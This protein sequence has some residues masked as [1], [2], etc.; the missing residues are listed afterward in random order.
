MC[1][2]TNF[3]LFNFLMT[4]FLAFD[5]SSRF[6][7]LHLLLKSNK[8]TFSFIKIYFQSIR[9]FLK[10]FTARIQTCPPLGQTSVDYWIVR[11]HYWDRH[12]SIT[13]TL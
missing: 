8:N 4:L 10:T 7:S 2:A 5:T 6:S 9:F 1:H 13:G 3:I 11:D 12:M